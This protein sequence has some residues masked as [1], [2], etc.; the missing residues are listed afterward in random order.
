M[1]E[2]QLLLLVLLLLIMG[3]RSAVDL[4]KQVPWISN[5]GWAQLLLAIVLG[6]LAAWVANIDLIAVVLPEAG[7]RFHLLGVIMTGIGLGGGGSLIH[8]ALDVRQG[9]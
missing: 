9:E 6:S 8:D 3:I 4:A 7:D 2:N 1:S 5:R